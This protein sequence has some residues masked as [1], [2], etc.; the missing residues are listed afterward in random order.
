M[1]QKFTA[2]YNDRWMSGSHMHALTKFKRVELKSEESVDE[3]LK[4]EEISGIVEYLFEGWPK[5]QGEDNE[6]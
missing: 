2:V 4:R 1:N 3:M 6:S 5:L